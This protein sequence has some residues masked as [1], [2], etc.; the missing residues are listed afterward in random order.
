MKPD[1]SSDSSRGSPRATITAPPEASGVSAGAA[2]TPNVEAR[3]CEAFVLA[4][5]DVI[6]MGA[7]GSVGAKDE[8]VAIDRETGRFR[9]A[10][11]PVAAETTIVGVRVTDLAAPFVASE[12]RLCGICGDAIWLSRHDPALARLLEASAKTACLPCASADGPGADEVITSRTAVEH[13]LIVLLA[14]VAEA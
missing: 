11:P 2:P 6:D 5:Q 14:P 10:Q 9:A 13:A 1:Q 4:C 12:Q 8:Y 3:R 7:A